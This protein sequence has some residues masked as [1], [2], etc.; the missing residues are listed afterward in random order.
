MINKDRNF[1]LPILLTFI[2]SILVITFSYRHL[3]LFP[4]D[5]NFSQGGDGIKNYY[6]PAYYLNYGTGTQFYGNNYP[7]GTHLIC[8]DSHPFLVLFLNFIKP[9][10]DTTGHIV[11]IINFCML[12]SIALCSIFVFLILKRLN[13]PNWYTIIVSLL[14]TF[15]SPQIFRNIGHYALAYSCFVPAMWYFLIK[16]FENRHSYLWES[17]IVVYLF[18]FGL[19]HPYYLP[20]GTI[21]ILVYLVVYILQDKETLKTQFFFYSKIFLSAVIPVIFFKLFM[22][23]TETVSD[24]PDPW[25]FFHYRIHIEGIFLPTW[26]PFLD[27]WNYFIPVRFADFET[28]AYIGLPAT[29]ILIFS[30]IKILKYIKKKNYR[31]IFIPV[32]PEILRPA[33]WT[34][35]II[36]L[37]GMAIPFRFELEFLLDYLKPLKQ[38]RSLGR[39]AWVFYYIVTVYTSYYIFLIYRK[40]KPFSMTFAL[41]I[42]IL[43]LFSWTLDSSINIKANR[44]W[45]ASIEENN[46]LKKDVTYNRSFL[47][48][49]VTPVEFQAMAAFPFYN[50]GTEKIDRGN[51]TAL[52]AS[53]ITSY[54][55]KLPLINGWVARTSRSHGKK[56]MQFI[57]SEGIEKEI[58]KD[59][60]SSKP[61]LLMVSESEPLPENEEKL[62]QKAEF[63]FSEDG[64]KYYR[65]DIAN[66]NT[67]HA[68]FKEK[69]LGRKDSLYKHKNY[70]T[71]TPATSSV[72]YYQ[73]FDSLVSPEVFGGEGAVYGRNKEIILYTGVLPVAKDSVEM[74]V[75]YWLYLDS[76]LPF[77]Q[78]LYISE[79]NE[80][81][82]EK[83]VHEHHILEKDFD[84]HKGWIHCHYVFMAK[85]N[86][87]Y[88]FWL[89]DRFVIA[90]EFLLKETKSE[91]YTQVSDS[92]LF[93]NNYPLKIE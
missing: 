49:G 68:R 80:S 6:V 58:V 43:F 50:M 36:L 38:F 52:A 14:I 3:F 77:V 5:Y 39:F 85:P 69:A 32:L 66:L 1:L 71:L 35:I 88:K 57:S 41:S 40:L 16:S 84:I 87:N 70:F 61:I 48:K 83:N 4:N 44:E 91:I 21:F 34:A 54:H 93:Y 86:I 25:G 27:V 11:G 60:P 12:F 56:I 28:R 53:L 59:F 65:L 90:D 23:F 64:Y 13:L 51:T 10:F 29:L 45:L 82:G 33:I 30:V 7:Y 20:L 76:E 17:V 19:I 37:L 72:T 15:L 78:H 9:Y 8:A 79:L 2:I 75:S 24:R 74:E 62:V 67:G 81:T 18:V 89:K 55:L 46:A 26:G 92:F 22:H 63:L 47:N 31:K 42:L 73:S